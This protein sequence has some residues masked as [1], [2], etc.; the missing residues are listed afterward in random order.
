[1][2]WHSDGGG[3]ASCSGRHLGFPF[4]W[5]LC[6]CKSRGRKSLLTSHQITHHTTTK[7]S[8]KLIFLNSMILIAWFWEKDIPFGPPVCEV[9]LVVGSAHLTLLFNTTDLQ[10]RRRGYWRS[11]LPLVGDW[12]PV[13]DDKSWHQSDPQAAVCVLSDP[14]LPCVSCVPSVWSASMV[15][16]ASP[17]SAGTDSCRGPRL[18]TNYAHHHM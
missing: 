13:Y 10:Q 15:P 5:L 3:E 6:D 8:I 2:W 14:R 1:M 4:T 18:L 17:S 16:L 11:S 12:C 9:D 7:S